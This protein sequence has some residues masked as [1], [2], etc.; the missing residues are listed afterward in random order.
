MIARITTQFGEAYTLNGD[1]R[2][3]GPDNVIVD[4][5]NEFYVPSVYTGAEFVSPQRAAIDYA[6]AS[7]GGQTIVYG[8]EL[9]PLRQGED[10]EIN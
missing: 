1:G 9:E 4:A 8:S 2:W 3:D 6:Y 5:L 7:L 10:R